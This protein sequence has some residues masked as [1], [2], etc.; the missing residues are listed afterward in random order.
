[1]T[2]ITPQAAHLL[3]PGD[4]APDFSLLATPDQRVSLSEVIGP[5]VL[6]FYPADWSPVCGDELSVFEAASGLFAARGAQLLGISV[7]S[8]WSHVAFRA[9]RKLEF[10]L[11]A[12]FNPKGEVARAYGAYRPEDGTSER[13]LFVVDA[14]G[15][16]RWSHLSPVGINPGADG[17]LQAVEAL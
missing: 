13:A 14:S 3:G 10:P 4:Q 11:L 2:A 6:I 12:D 1:M 15:V 16:I 17:A 8:A 7:D 5:V 9:E